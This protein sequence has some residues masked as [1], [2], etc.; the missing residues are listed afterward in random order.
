MSMKEPNKAIPTQENEERAL[1]TSK[2]K[3]MPVKTLCGP[4]TANTYGCKP[5]TEELI[6][7]VSRSIMD[8]KKSLRIG[9]TLI[10][11]GIRQRSL[12]AKLMLIKEVTSTR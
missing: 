8:T 7:S 1:S 2:H 11:Q 4:L 12:L 5:K 3:N 9:L 6:I 10:S